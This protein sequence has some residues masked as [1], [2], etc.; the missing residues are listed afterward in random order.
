MGPH[1]GADFTAETTFG[2]RWLLRMWNDRTKTLLPVGV[3][4]ANDQTT[5][6][7]TSGSR[8]GR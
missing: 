1:S 3:G 8:A 2:V 5:A 6:T 4:E 7:T